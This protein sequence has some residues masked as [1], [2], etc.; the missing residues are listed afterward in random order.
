MKENKSRLS[1]M[2]TFPRMEMQM[3]YPEE[4]D[5]DK[6]FCQEKEKE[7]QKQPTV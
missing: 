3:H 5:A 1:K 7:M 6:Q 4:Y 2:E